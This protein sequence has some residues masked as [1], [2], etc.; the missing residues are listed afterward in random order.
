MSKKLI[1]LVLSFVLFVSACAK[2]DN[3]TSVSSPNNAVTDSSDVVLEDAGDLIEVRPATQ[4]GNGATVNNVHVS[5][6]G[7]TVIG[8]SKKDES[9][10]SSSESTSSG[11]SSSGTQGN[12]DPYDE[13]PLDFVLDFD[14]ENIKVLQ[15]SD[16]MVID[17]SQ[18]R[19]ETTMG[20]ADTIKYDPSKKQELLFNEIKSAVDKSNPDLI[21]ITGDL[22][23]G[24]YDDLGTSFEAVINYMDSLKIFWAPVFGTYDNSS[25]QGVEWQCSKLKESKYCL[26]KRSNNVEGNSNYSIGLGVKGKLSRVIYMLDSNG[27]VNST[28]PA[29]ITTAGIRDTQLQWVEN[30]NN[31]LK[32]KGVNVPSFAC[33]NLLSSDVLDAVVNAGY[34]DNSNTSVYEIGKDIT[35]KNRDFGVKGEPFTT[36]FT[37]D[38][39]LT[40]FKGVGVDGVFMGSNPATDISVLYNDILW[41]I[42]LK[43]GTY[44]KATRTGGMLIKISGNS[45]SVSEILV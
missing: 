43:T 32:G 1:V 20:T 40:T 37:N 17:S 2:T 31:S 39:L 4:T 42:G 15:L 38:K 18:Q 33:F 28:D 41:T 21:L 19:P 34:E 22:V 5:K 7:A 30:V 35:A 3:N 6:S 12:K 16:F 26:F 29:V 24:F 8:I 11:T 25:A 45:F 36:M 14:T 10:N 44:Y 27:C 9:G 23:M 13:L